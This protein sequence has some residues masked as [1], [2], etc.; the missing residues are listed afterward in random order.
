M[1]NL[2]GDA[3]APTL[4]LA[5]QLNRSAFHSASVGILYP[6]GQG[7]FTPLTP[8]HRLSFVVERQS[9]GVFGPKINLP[10]TGWSVLLNVAVVAEVLI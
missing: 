6:V 7:L 10:S 2:R 9:Y 4:V 1:G 8:C 5:L 3:K